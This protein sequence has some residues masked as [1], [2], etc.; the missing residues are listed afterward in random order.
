VSS[1]LALGPRSI[2]PYVLKSTTEQLHIVRGGDEENPD[3]LLL[4]ISG[5]LQAQTASFETTSDTYALQVSGGSYFQ[6]N[7][8][9]SGM[10]TQGASDARLKANVTTLPHALESVTRLRGVSF[11]W[12][13]DTPQPFRGNDVGLIAQD[14]QSVL[15]T[16]VCLAPFDRC[17]TDP[18]RSASSASYLTIDSTGNQLVGLLVEAVKEL[19]NEIFALKFSLHTGTTMTEVNENEPSIKVARFELYPAEEPTV[20]C[21]GFAETYRS[22]VKY[23]DTQISL[24]DAAGKSDEEIV[25]VAWTA[26]ESQFVAWR[27]Q[28]ANRSPLIGSLFV[29]PFVPPI[30]SP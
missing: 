22:R 15:P 6:G 20:Y 19:R 10:L 14:V 3:P 24:E 23:A 18:S 2:V 17:P 13:E 7:I 11:S 16:A 28:L 21:V 5:N 4:K 12:R 9:L 30:E 27:D 1:N 29:P 25:N 26:L 8:G